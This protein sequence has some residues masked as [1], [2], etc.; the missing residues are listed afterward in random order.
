MSSK[1]AENFPNWPNLTQIGAEKTNHESNF[2]QLGRHS[3]K[4]V[5]EVQ[6]RAFDHFVKA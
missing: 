1:L 3:T 4:I 2:S 5:A 6:L